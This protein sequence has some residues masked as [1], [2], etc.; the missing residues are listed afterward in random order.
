MT[1][2]LAQILETISFFL[3]SPS[4][5]VFVFGR[6]R[7]EVIGGFLQKS[8]M[9]ITDF[10]AK[11]LIY[12]GAFNRTSILDPM[13]TRH[14]LTRQVVYGS[15]SSDEKTDK[16]K[17]L[18]KRR[19]RQFAFFFFHIADLV[20]KWRD[21]EITK[22]KFWREIRHNWPPV[23]QK[24]K[25]FHKLIFDYYLPIMLGI[26][27]PFSVIADSLRS[28]TSVSEY[29]RT[30][31]PVFLKAFYYDALFLI[32]IYIIWLNYPS[33]RQLSFVF[34]PIVYMCL[35]LFLGV[36]LFLLFFFSLWRGLARLGDQLIPSSARLLIHFE[37]FVNL[38]RS[39]VQELLVFVSEHTLGKRNALRL[40][41]AGLGGLGSYLYDAQDVLARPQTKL[42]RSW[43]LLILISANYGVAILLSFYFEDSSLA[44]HLCLIIVGVIG[45]LLYFPYAA[46]FSVLA[47]LLPLGFMSNI[48]LVLLEKREKLMSF[49]LALGI[50]TFLIAKM[51]AIAAG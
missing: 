6:N 42:S 48:T 47:L 30:T 27:N 26:R 28:K 29:V 32:G 18:F 14:V 37:S 46:V 49:L 23:Y 11:A 34:L 51:L 17:T 44:L 9:F 10:N 3:V 38:V 5:L 22:S 19:F 39:S 2:A 40:L 25:Q 12:L 41:S 21:S 4:I 20:L 13:L 45:I 16:Q 33:I 1:N 36:I 15:L 31:Y 35:G 8:A 7:L 24:S 50:L 43:R